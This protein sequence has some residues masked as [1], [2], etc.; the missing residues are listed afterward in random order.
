MSK[1]SLGSSREVVQ[2]C[3]VNFV[4]CLYL[5]PLIIGQNFCATC[6]TTNQT[7]PGDVATVGRSRTCMTADTSPR[8]PYRGHQHQSARAT[9]TAAG[10]PPRP[11]RDVHVAPLRV[12]GQPIK[13]R[14]AT[15]AAGRQERSGRGPTLS[16]AH[17]SGSSPCNRVS[18]GV[19][20][21]RTM[22]D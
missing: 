1:V 4:N 9:R 5:V 17:T 21:P 18:S 22:R 3:G 7:W 2:G 11:P 12:R 10:R 20:I 16:R 8:R 15:H 19:S 6:A 14:G 13:S